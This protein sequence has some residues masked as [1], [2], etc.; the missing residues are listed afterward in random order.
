[1]IPDSLVEELLPQVRRNCHLAD[2]AV[3]GHFSLCGL[4][5]RLRNLYKWE[6][7]LPPW[8]EQD[9]EPMLEWVS[10]REDLWQGLTDAEP[11]PLTVDGRSFDPFDTVGLNRLLEPLGLLYGAGRVGGLLPVFFL[12]RL[13]ERRREDGLTVHVVG[14]EMTSDLF[15][16]PGMRQG[17]AIFLR[18]S[19]LPYLLWDK[20]TDP[21]P[22]LRRFLRFGLAG[23]GLEMDRLVREP[24]W[25]LLQPVL[26]GELRAVGWH[27]RG[28][29][30]DAEPAVGL[31][32]RV[33]VEHP[34]S[35]LEHFV[36]GLKDLLADCGPRGRLAAIVAERAVGALGLYPAWLA[37]F[38][39]LIFPEVDAAVGE[40]IAG[41]DW[42]AVEEVRV[43]GWARARG[44][45]D[46]LA[47]V[48]A[49]HSG[50]EALAAARIRV[51]GP[52]TG[53]RSLPAEQ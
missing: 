13:L 21:R 6:N 43:L 2:A 40:V 51:I 10:R 4:L 14:K 38:P 25:E 29:A 19:P 32:H 22:S 46:E 23:Y 42:S 44:A 8:R 24:S 11:A 39:R 18:T 17:P 31:L 7:G 16:L 20:L 45:L 12:G 28:E 27:E 34:G 53:G 48:V 52:L 37:G 3:S 5:L 47:E 26:D 33:A 9:S 35:E 49:R 41:G 30:T 15:F 1:M 50:P 36:R